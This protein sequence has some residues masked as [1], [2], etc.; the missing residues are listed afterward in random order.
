VKFEINAET[1]AELGRSKS[2]RLRQLG[3]IPAVVYGGGKDPSPIT[4][5]RNSLSIQMAQEAFYTS[6]LDLKLGKKA[7]PVVVK[8]VQRHP[9]KSTVLH[10]DLQ[11]VVEDEELTLNVPVRFV[12]EEVAV[13]VKE[14]GGVLERVVTDI[15][16]SCLPANLPEFLELDVSALELNEILHLSDIKYPEG[17]SSTQLAHGHDTPVAA[18]HPPRR[19]EVEEP[20]LEEGEELEAAAEGEGE[21]ADSE[22]TEGEDSATE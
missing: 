16:I 7:Q 22:T 17:V 4:L 9:A 13:G 3:Q 10:L 5:D 6:I 15:E 2:R 12:G 20:E 21:A 8:E 1:R 19:E 18:I 14:Q 11:R